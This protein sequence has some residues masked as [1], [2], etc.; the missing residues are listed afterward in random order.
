MKEWTFL[1]AYDYI[2]AN[3]EAFQLCD[4]EEELKG[5]YPSICVHYFF[6]EPHDISD[7]FAGKLRWTGTALDNKTKPSVDEELQILL[8]EHL[9]L[10][11]GE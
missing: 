5:N 11:K 8:N 7:S 4:D 3:P 10:T 1:E 9:A 6:K 2:K